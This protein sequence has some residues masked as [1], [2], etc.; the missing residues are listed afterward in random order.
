ML[1]VIM[2]VKIGNHNVFK[3][4]IYESQLPKGLGE[5]MVGHPRKDSMTTVPKISSQNENYKYCYC[6]K[7]GSNK[8]FL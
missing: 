6:I 7:T 2:Q 8:I 1:K 4:Q 3:E 5:W